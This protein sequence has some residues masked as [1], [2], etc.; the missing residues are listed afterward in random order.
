MLLLNDRTRRIGNPGKTFIK[1][2]KKKK[3]LD[4]ADCDSKSWLADK[5]FYYVVNSFY[6]PQADAF[7][8]S[9]LPASSFQITKC[10]VG[11]RG[12]AGAKIVRSVLKQLLVQDQIG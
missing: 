3:F 1:I 11:Y 9:S 8:F 7:I 12:I 6:D 2:V 5:L 10:W 4:H